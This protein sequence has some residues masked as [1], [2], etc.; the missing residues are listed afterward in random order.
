MY[1]LLK[2]SL[3]LIFN[4]TTLLYCY[5]SCLNHAC[6]ISATTILWIH[7]HKNITR[8]EKILQVEKAGVLWFMNNEHIIPHNTSISYLNGLIIII[9]FKFLC[10]KFKI[11]MF[12]KITIIL[13]TFVNNTANIHVNDLFHYFLTRQYIR[14]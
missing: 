2:Q 10:I 14:P 3:N 7:I 13:T 4:I 6:L 11:F 5:I 12:S 8:N 1:I 9:F